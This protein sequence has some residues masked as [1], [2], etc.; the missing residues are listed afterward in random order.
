[1]F[2]VSCFDPGRAGAHR[3]VGFRTRGRLRQSVGTCNAEIDMSGKNA[4]KKTLHCSQ[5][6]LACAHK[7]AQLA[8]SK[9]AILNNT[10]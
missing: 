6:V 10:E 8:R 9:P 2:M 4:A 3:R 7:S 5:I 1:M